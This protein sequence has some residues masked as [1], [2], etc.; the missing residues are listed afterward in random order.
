MF[1]VTHVMGA[2]ET[3]LEQAILTLKNADDQPLYSH[4]ECWNRIAAHVESLPVGSDEIWAIMDSTLLL[5]DRAVAESAALLPLSF[6]LDDASTKGPPF[7]LGLVKSHILTISQG[8]KH[9]DIPWFND[10]GTELTKFLR[11]WSDLTDPIAK[12]ALSRESSVFASMALDTLTVLPASAPRRNSVVWAAKCLLG[13]VPAGAQGLL[14]DRLL[15]ALTSDLEVIDMA[16]EWQWNWPVTTNLAGRVAKAW[17]SGAGDERPRLK[18]LLA[19]RADQQCADRAL[20]WILADPTRCSIEPQIERLF[21][22]GQFSK[23]SLAAWRTAAWEGLASETERDPR[24]FMAAALCMQPDPRAGIALSDMER[25][26]LGAAMGRADGIRPVMAILLT[27]ALSDDQ[28]SSAELER[29]SEPALTAMTRLSVGGKGNEGVANAVAVLGLARNFPLTG[30]TREALVAQLDAVRSPPS[31]T[32]LLRDL[33]VSNAPSENGLE[34]TGNKKEEIGRLRVKLMRPDWKGGQ[35][36]LAQVV[37]QIPSD[38]VLRIVDAVL[39]RHD[40]SE[41]GKI[42]RPLIEREWQSSKSNDV[43][44]GLA[45]GM[46]VICGDVEQA[47]IWLQSLT[48]T[49]KSDEAF[50]KQVDRVALIDPNHQVVAGPASLWRRQKDQDPSSAVCLWLLGIRTKDSGAAFPRD[51]YRQLNGKL[52]SNSVYAQIQLMSADLV[53]YFDKLADPKAALPRYKVS[54]ASALPLAKAVAH[55]RSQLVAINA[56]QKNK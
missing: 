55:V 16:S 7:R 29:L 38:Q 51:S 54:A 27:A 30:P 49:N 40:R 9:R 35:D 23:Q 25:S 41:F 17:D 39:Y 8:A 22:Q 20:T 14:I 33:V 34:S 21:S 6:Q 50:T 18:S 48:L 42:L 19:C 47:R 15:V 56:E 24:L 26:A 46:A 13:F 5:S 44:L 31:A 45:A 3:D 2:D 37:D 43:R 11:T 12:D 4:I 1:C 10:G 36:A 28:M 32:E 53:P 52:N